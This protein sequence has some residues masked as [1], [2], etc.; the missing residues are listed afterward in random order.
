MIQSVLSRLTGRPSSARVEREDALR[1]LQLML[2]GGHDPTVQ[3]VAGALGVAPDRAAA[4]LADLERRECVVFQ[5]GRVTLTPTGQA[6]ATHII[7]AHRL[8][9]QHLAQSSGVPPEQWHA[10]ADRAEHRLSP[11]DVAALTERLGNPTH[12]PHGDPIPPPHGAVV[13]HHG[14]PLDELPVD[15]TARV[16]HVEDEPAMVFAE[17][18]MLGLYPGAIVRVVERGPHALGLWVD[19]EHVTLTPLMVHNVSVAPLAAPPAPAPVRL[20]ALPIGRS[21]TVA[22]LSPACRGTERRRLLDLGFVPGTVIT[23][24]MVSPSGD[25]TAYAVRGALI[26]LRRTQARHVLI[27]PAPPEA[28]ATS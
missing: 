11:D 2:A 21:A 20:S 3:S 10:H 13:P 27:Q 19:G 17:L 14:M 28:E 18:V 24:E 1:H 7:R 22:G 12:D 4:V 15:Q 5:A 23:A 26:A 6:Y 9:E 8:W 25:P 16:T